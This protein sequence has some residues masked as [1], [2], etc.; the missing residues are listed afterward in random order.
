MKTKR[1]MMLLMVAVF[2][3]GVMGLALAADVK[4]TVAKIE[5]NQLTIQDDMGKQM[6]FQVPDP[7]AIQDLKVGDR[8][9]VAQVGNTVKVTKEG[10]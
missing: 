7:K 5:G 1:M 9:V 10:G 3:L 2:T 8:V 6:T 4:G